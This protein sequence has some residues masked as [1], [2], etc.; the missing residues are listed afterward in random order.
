MNNTNKNLNAINIPSPIQARPEWV[1]LYQSLMAFEVNHYTEAPLSFQQRLMREHGWTENYMQRVWFEYKR[2]L[3]MLAT[4]ERFIC[5]AEDVDQI[6][7]AHLIYTRSYWNDLCRDL[8][9]KP[10]HH[11]PS[12]GGVEETQ[13]FYTCYAATLERYQQ[14]F[15][16]PAPADIWVEPELRL[17]DTPYFRLINTRTHWVMPKRWLSKPKYLLGFS[18]ASGLLLGLSSKAYADTLA[19]Y[20][21]T[22]FSIVML[23]ASVF[24]FLFIVHFY[25]SYCPQCGTWLALKRTGKVSKTEPPEHEYCCKACDYRRWVARDSSGGSGGGCGGSGG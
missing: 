20:F 6:W 1:G 23:I 5:P 22:Y 8:L 19:D 7:H 11:V 18:V 25:R 16:E 3:F 14:L 2:F 4:T 21:E 24:V 17:Q 13:H 12:P 9:G 10:L 15:G